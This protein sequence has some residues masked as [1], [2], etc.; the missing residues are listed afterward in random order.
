MSMTAEQRERFEKWM[1]KEWPSIRLDFD[2]ESGMYVSSHAARMCETWQAAE[3]YSQSLREELAQ[4]RERL[5][6]VSFVVTGNDHALISCSPAE[7]DVKLRDYASGDELER[8][9]GEHASLQQSYAD[10]WERAEAENRRL[11][12]ALQQVKV[13]FVKLEAEEDDKVL[14]ALRKKYHAPVHTILDAALQPRPT[15]SVK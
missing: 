8:M 14:L 6:H 2:D 13:W 5:K 7:V 4:A 9:R 12:E 11:R 10:V 15:E 1:Q 3:A